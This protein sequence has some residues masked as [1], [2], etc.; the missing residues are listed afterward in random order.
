MISLERIVDKML[1]RPPSPLTLEPPQ[2]A[3]NPPPPRK[4]NNRNI[5]TKTA[6]RWDGFPPAGSNMACRKTYYWYF[7]SKPH[8]HPFWLD[9]HLPCLIS[10]GYSIWVCV[11]NR[12]PPLP[13]DYYH[14]PYSNDYYL[15]L[16]PIFRPTIYYNNVV[17]TIRNH[18][19]V[20]TNL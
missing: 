2:P 5:T 16:S 8:K 7:P 20:I 13:I 14:V 12:V 3:K 9:F 4:N 15:W 1:L 18:P 6:K 11:R 17:K 10:G 19:P